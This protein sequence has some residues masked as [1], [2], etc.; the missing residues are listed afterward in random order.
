MESQRKVKTIEQAVRNASLETL[1]GMKVEEFVAQLKHRGIASLEDLA[2]ASIGVAHSGVGG[3]VVQLDPE[4]FP[5]CFPFTVR[6]FRD[7]ATDLA[8]VADRVKNSHFGG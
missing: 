8:K 4:D 2:K 1:A 7:G 5:V 3:S 6:P